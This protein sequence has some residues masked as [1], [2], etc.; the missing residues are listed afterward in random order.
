M[1]RTLSLLLVCIMALSML[2]SCAQ[3]EGGSDA[4]DTPGET[5]ATEEIG[6]T[7]FQEVLPER[8]F[9]GYT[10]NILNYDPTVL[11]WLVTELT[12]EEE[13]GETINDAIFARN[14]KIEEKFNVKINETRVNSSGNVE[15]QAKKLI[16]AGAEDFDL[17]MTVLENTMALA[18]Q[19]LLV[20][21]NTIPY[22]NLDAPY[23]DQDLKR[24]LSYN[25]KIFLMDGDFDLTHYS[26]VIALFFN[27]QIAKD[28]NLDDPYQLVN[29][30]KWTMDAFYNMAKDVT[31]DIDGNG[32]W[33]H[34]DLYGYMS[35][36]FLIV[37]TWLEAAGERVISKDAD[38]KAILSVNTGRFGDVFTKMVDICY[39]G[40]L[41]Y[42]ADAKGDHRKQDI[43]FPGNKTLFW[44]ELV[45][46]SKIL[47]EMDSDF[48][49]LPNP[50]FDEAQESYHSYVQN[51]QVM[52]V[53]TTTADLERTGIL[54][55]ALCA[56]SRRV[57][58]PAYYESMLKTKIARDNDSQTMLDIMFGN[59]RY[60]LGFTLWRKET[61][62]V[63]INMF[64]KQDTGI[65]SFLEKQSDKLNAA[66]A[67]TDDAFAALG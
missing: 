46:W 30:G 14:S 60:D 39:S 20:D 42:D 45:Q 6:T 29:E 43:M 15:T 5:V 11:T 21:Y 52:A 2:A 35:L 55:E 4:T 58:V 17:Y 8:D 61:G 24:D 65:A 23:W 12:A 31:K 57:V 1:K 28:Y 32:K 34:E 13:N 40:N 54:L 7:E 49:I 53:P 19:G 10:F 62:E 63:L 25:N 26:A 27:K 9:E 51:P 64:K 37:P 22:I 47:R 56:E 38:G 36:N 50:K 16:A 44:N 33:T 41:L 67:K 48:G 18:T 66:I 3:E 59:R